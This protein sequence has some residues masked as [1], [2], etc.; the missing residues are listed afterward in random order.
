MF[1]SP[2]T[3]CV[4]LARAL[5]APREPVIAD[6]LQEM[7]FGAWEGKPWADIPRD[8]LDAW[9]ADVWS[10]APGGTESAAMVAQ[11][12][13]NWCTRLPAAA[14]GAAIAVTH[15]GV[16]RVALASARTLD[17]VDIATAVDFGAVYRIDLAGRGACED[18]LLTAPLGAAP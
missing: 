10:Y 15:A 16:I 18:S 5:A 2:A 7:N 6:D 1:S 12:W 17:A 8:E 14:S 11:R 4:L 13:R 9:A 3:R